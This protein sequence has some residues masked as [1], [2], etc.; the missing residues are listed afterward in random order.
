MILIDQLDKICK[1]FPDKIAI[2][3]KKKRLHSENLDIRLG[4]LDFL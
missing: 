3:D 4:A 2:V 1:K